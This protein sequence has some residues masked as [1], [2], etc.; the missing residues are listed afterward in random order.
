MPNYNA[1]NPPNSVYPG[2][3]V[4]AFNAEAPAAGQA[5]QQFAL[6][7]YSGFP[8]NGRTIRWQT[9]FG[10]APT[11]VSV[12]LQTAMIDSDAQYAT[13]DTS[14]ATTGEARTVAGVRGNF[15]RAKVSAITGGSGVT[16][17]LLG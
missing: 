17:Q 16:V 7:S 6:P 10:T 15:I 1:Q 13:V 5:S 12:V 3:V 14:T 9:I 2:D 4:F 11:S 8:E